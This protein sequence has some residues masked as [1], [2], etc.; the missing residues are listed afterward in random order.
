MLPPNPGLRRFWIEASGAGYVLGEIKRLEESCVS[1]FGSS[2]DLSIFHAEDLV[3]SLMEFLDIN[4][5]LAAVA[6]RSVTDQ[7]KN[8]VSRPAV[9]PKIQAGGRESIGN[10]TAAEKIYPSGTEPEHVPANEKFSITREDARGHFNQMSDHAGALGT[11]DKPAIGTSGDGQA[12][13]GAFLPAPNAGLRR[14]WIEAS[15]ADYV[16]RQIRT[17]EEKWL[18]SSGANSDFLIFHEEDLVRPL[19]DPLGINQL[20]PGD[21]APSDQAAHSVGED[22]CSI[23]NHPVPAATPQTLT[24]ESLGLGKEKSGPL[25]QHARVSK[26][27]DGAAE[28]QTRAA[29]HKSIRS[30]TAAEEIHPSGNARERV[31]A[32]EKCSITRGDARSHFN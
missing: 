2:A 23:E 25:R 5:S 4:K 28:A 13:E 15:G 17:P 14:L 19:V 8:V 21:V 18:S 6:A 26:E 29:A 16:M 27:L 9:K 12:L 7:A 30:G 3:Q 22:R 10:G 1:L 20:L 11:Q 32:S 24:S 31:S